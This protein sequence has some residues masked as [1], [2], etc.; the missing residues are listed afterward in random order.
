MPS[1]RQ[2]R[3]GVEDGVAATNSVVKDSVPAWQEVMVDCF[4]KSQRSTVTHQGCVSLLEKVY[5]R[6]GD[7]C[8][9]DG[10]FLD[11][12]TLLQRV[13]L[14]YKREPHVERLVA[15]VARAVVAMDAG[16]E[17]PGFAVRFLH[18]LL[19]LSSAKEKAVRFRVCQ[20]TALVLDAM[21][22]DAELRLHVPVVLHLTLVLSMCLLS[23][24]LL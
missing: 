18:Q 20:L 1:V 3:K 19:H 5:P 6:M 14:V 10:F 17:D 11:F 4:H 9:Q 21:G 15:F 24:N 16:Q 23:P 13:L 8:L 12:W 7:P 22:P 2:R